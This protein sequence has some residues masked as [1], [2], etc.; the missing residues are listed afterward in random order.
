MNMFL[1]GRRSIAGRWRA[2]MGA[3]AL[4][5]GAPAFGALTDLATAPLETSSATLVKPNIMF[6]LDNS[7]SMASAYLPDWADDYSASSYP[8]L[9][10]NS[11]FNGIY[12][13]PSVTYS[14]P[15]NYAGTS[16]TSMTS[17]N[18]SAWAKVPTDGFGIISTGTTDLTGTTTPATYYTF[19]PGEYCSSANLRTC[20]KQSAATT[21]YAYPAYLRW[22]TTSALSTCQAAYIDSTSAPATYKY[23]RY[24]GISS[25][26]T[27]V[28]SGSSSTSISGITVNGVQILSATTTASTSS[29]T[30][31]TNIV[32]A[33]NNCTSS[34][35]GNCG[36]AGY[37]AS[38]SGSTVTITSPKGTDAYGYSP[39]VTQSGSM[40]A[41]VTAFSG[42]TPGSWV[43]TTISSST[44]TYAYPGTSARSTTRTDCTTN[45][46]TCTYAEEMTNFANWWAY[47]HTRMQTMKSAT[48]LAF[49]GLTSSYRLGY[50]TINKVSSSTDFLN[51]ADNTTTSGGQKSLWYGKLVA[52]QASSTTP[53]RT[54]LS[55]AGRYFAAKV[56][57]INGVTTTDP[58][59]YACQRNY[60]LLSTDGYWNETAT[61][62]KADGSTAIGDQDSSESRPYLDGNKVSNTLADVAEY[63]YVTDL[64]SSS[65]SNT[66][67][68]SGTDVSSNSYSNKRQNMVTST[69]GL[70]ASGYMLFDADYANATS[71]DY[72]D[73]ANG[74]TTSS[75]TQTSGV[76][77]WQ[78][79]GSC[80]WPTPVSDTQT[81]I[82]DLWHA[83]VNGRG[84]YYSAS[85]AADI[86][87]GLTNFLNTVDATTSSSAAVAQS[88]PVLT[89]TTAG[90]TFSTTYCSGKWFGELARYAVDSSTGVTST[91]A[92]WAESGAGS[93]CSSTSG[94]LTTTALLDNVGYASRTIFTYD[95]S[96]ATKLSFSWD[97]LTTT[98]QGYFK[99]AS[100]SS[101]S[102]LCSSGSACL[103][104]ASQVNSSTA[105]TTTGAG[106]VNLV[107]Y[108]RGD[109]SNEGSTNTKYY[110]SRTHVLGD[111]VNSTP[112]YIKAPSRSYSDSGYATFKSTYASRQGMV[113]VGSNDGMLHAFNADTGAETWAYIP[114]VLLPNLYKLADKN[115][116]SNHVYFVDGQI[117]QADVYYNSA[118]HTIIVGGLGDG[119]RA[120]FALD[121][122]DPASPTVLWEFSSSS[123]LTPNLYDVDLGYTYGAP[124]ITK[125]SDGTWAVIL[126]SGY[127]NVSDG[128]GEGH[129]WVRNAMTG[130]LIKKIDNGMGTTSSGGTVTGC[131]VAPCPSGL[132]K[133]SG[134]TNSST[135]NTT[136]QLY[137]GDL[138]GNLWRF[139]I[140]ALAS[141]SGSATVQLLATL[142]DSSGN[143]QPITTAPELGLVSSQH[144]VF[145]GTGS[146]LGVT[147]ITTTQVQ[148]MYAIKD[149]LS[150]SST[151]S[152]IYSNPRSN[153]CSTG[154]VT[155]CFVKLTLTDTSGVRTAASSVSYTTN[156]STMYGWFVD[157]PESGERVD[158]DPVLSSGTLVYVSNTPSTSGACSTGGSSYINYVNY[159]TGLAVS[160]AS[161]TGVL[162][163]SSGLSSSAA[164][165]VTSSGKTVATTKDST[166]TVTTT[167]IPV[168][169]SSSTRRISWRR[170]TD[171]Q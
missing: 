48:T 43:Q 15:V 146:Y 111:V 110:R 42:G 164:L 22:C 47:Y 158:E 156:F 162:L 97:A 35:T 44:S 27:I 142:S 148:S 51:I 138:F 109:R 168:S 19:I 131:S 33:I 152:A 140:S 10:R 75:T 169:S 16:Y 73:V 94:S 88:A 90:Y 99:I 151:T 92:D 32:T 57:S 147:D 40:T 86:K 18:T 154:T 7:G 135:D 98:M 163:S 114:S 141:S 144:V 45:S 170:L 9:Y 82:D 93:D 41:T 39:V 14:P 53:L 30:V 89:S 68:S 103:A 60:T 84:S 128:D 36:I 21:A 79:S 59:Q 24:P 2:C 125:L 104:T 78:S 159:T 20:N 113:Y 66:T 56:S 134:W 171:G 11:R 80:N 3:L 8:Y 106:A 37:S 118:W 132:A 4:I 31:A 71:G 105:G 63:Y 26:A 17:A 69:I 46:T 54:A 85:N 122:T 95:P 91:T 117:T 149:S 34:K 25:T 107:N 6:I 126:S 129:L 101:L 150:G 167:T 137:G 67:N 127:N 100:I 166:G 160:G 12:Y 77:G 119:G 29:T 76:C 102:Q 161:N 5:L 58:M 143:R 28:I 115:Y 81:A 65:L 23:P 38:R 55:N 133:I 112:V 165:A 123:T 70:G 52:A 1:P 116:A 121:V 155:N 50:M 13:D 124:V 145:V 49:S 74:T 108:L 62:Y 72:Y 96:T 130:A 87:T 139:D 61:P 64:R 120:Y 136:T 153:A 83:A 157:M